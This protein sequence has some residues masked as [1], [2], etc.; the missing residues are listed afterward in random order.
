MNKY[1]K[2]IFHPFLFALYPVLF[3]FAYNVDQVVIRDITLPLLLAIALASI[4][5]GIAWLVTRDYQK[6][7]FIATLG[8]ILFFSYGHVFELQ[9]GAEWTRPRYLLSVWA[10]LFLGGSY[11]IIRFV[12]ESA[13]FTRILNGIALLL[14]IMV[15]VPIGVSRTNEFSTRSFSNIQKES[16][17]PVTHQETLPDIYYIILDAYASE[18]V[19]QGEFGYDNSDF[20]NF[21]TEKGFFVVPNSHSNYSLSKYSL[22]SSLNMEYLDQLSAQL[23]FASLEDLNLREAVENNRVQRFLRE[24]G[25][26]FIHFGTMWQTTSANRFAD[27]N[28]GVEYYASEFM[29]ALY[30]KTALYPID[31][32]FN[33]FDRRIKYRYI[34]S[35]FDS[36]ADVASRPEPTFVF[37]HFL[38][39]HSPY[40][41]AA[42]GA[43]VPN[44]SLGFEE[45]KEGYLNQLIFL[46]TKVRP[47]VERILSESSSPP[48]IILQGDHGSRLE[49]Q[50]GISEESPSFAWFAEERLG[51]LNA[52]YLP[53][54]IARGM[55]YDTITP[56]N[57]FRI[58]FNVYFGQ[59][60]ELLPDKQFLSWGGEWGGDKFMEVTSLLKP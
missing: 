12:K 37:A 52:Y 34:L 50:E 38:M 23:G 58:I 51:N 39:P 31:K 26:K 10:F 41:F 45:E 54:K 29:L 44:E 60:H 20:V 40:V 25:Y 18:E 14:V 21:L 49:R 30:E 47:L 19:L 16:S 9:A 8:I 59:E 1:T 3:L 7:G 36:V 42:D 33:H 57:T 48:I 6:A 5:F 56:V 2:Y 4:L 35:H 24:Q 32:K 43:F 28:I 53:E 17:V 46:N 15:L 27:E 22:P 11:A 55:L 13:R